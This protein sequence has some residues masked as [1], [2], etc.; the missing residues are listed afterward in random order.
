MLIDEE[1]VGI[2]AIDSQGDE[3]TRNS[4]RSILHTQMDISIYFWGVFISIST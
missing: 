1:N 4:D 3:S 2:F